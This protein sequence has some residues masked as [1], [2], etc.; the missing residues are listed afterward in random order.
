MKRKVPISL[1]QLGM[2]LVRQFEVAIAALGAMRMPRGTI[3]HA[4]LSMPSE[5]VAG[6]EIRPIHWPVTISHHH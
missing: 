4:E 3:P 1:E 2:H 5:T 6:H